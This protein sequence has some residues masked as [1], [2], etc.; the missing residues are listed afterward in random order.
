MWRVLGR[1]VGWRLAREAVGDGANKTPRF[2]YTVGMS[3]VRG[4]VFDYG[5]VLS[6]PQDPTFFEVVREAMGLSREEV[7]AGWRRYRLGLDRGVLPVAALY[8][9]IGADYG[10]VVPDEVL[11][12]VGQADYDS[13]AHGNDAVLAWGRELKAA[14]YRLAILTN[15]PPDYLD[16]FERAAGAF[17]RL[18]EVEVVSG[19]EGV[20]KP[21]EAIYRLVEERMGLR[22]ESLFFLDDTARNVEAAQ[23]LGWG[24]AVFSTVEA[25]RA[26]LAA[27]ERGV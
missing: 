7:L 2:W 21:E 5:G 15:M 23:A 25:A 3:R 1:F 9:Q 4:I 22:G 10:V 16:C 8:R 24:G 27:Y 26:A 6:A 19:L 18:A 20:V 14:G 11:A 12:R 17:R 13:W